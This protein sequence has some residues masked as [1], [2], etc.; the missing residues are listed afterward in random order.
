M[1]GAGFRTL[2]SFL[3]GETN[4]KL[5]MRKLVVICVAVVI[6]ACAS[7]KAVDPYANATR[8]ALSDNYW[9]T[10]PRSGEL[11]VLGV[12][13]RQ[14]RRDYEIEKAT[15]DAARKISM[16]HSVWVRAQYEQN[17]GAGFFDYHVA[18]KTEIEY[19]K[20]LDQ[21]KEN[22]TFDP[23]RDFIRN[24]EGAVFIRFTYPISFPGTISYN[25]GKNPD[26]SPEWTTTPPDTISGF[27]A[28][29]GMSGRQEKV[30][31]TVMKSYEAAAVSIIKKIDGGFDLGD[32]VAGSQAYSHIYHESKGY[33]T[34]FL[35]LEVWID[36]KTR[37]A[38][39][40]AIASPIY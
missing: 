33:L 10:L 27:I 13:G 24:S 1:R 31:D 36:P 12:V 16:Y 25:S 28:G 38:Y 21:Y 9:I 15:E 3:N 5:Y 40:L 8:P 20:Q 29:V 34:N 6:N 26:G 23:D 14:S 30:G 17:I 35:A 18:S 11:V 22:L 19:D 37:A 2:F 39:T 4:L 32:S 7:S